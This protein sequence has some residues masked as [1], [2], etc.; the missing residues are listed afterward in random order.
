MNAPAT[1]V[2]IQEGFAHLP[3]IEL[4]TLLAPV[5]DHPVGSTVSRQTLELHGY[6]CS[7][8]NS[9]PKRPRWPARQAA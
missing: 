1:F 2:G 9:A 6:E 7:A 5:G 8:V 3:A 4:Y